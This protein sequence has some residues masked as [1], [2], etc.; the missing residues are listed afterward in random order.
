MEQ[1]LEDAGP[2]T[3]H[4]RMPGTV[5]IEGR[6][7][8]RRPSHPEENVEELQRELDIRYKLL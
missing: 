6:M 3:G 1:Q 7:R 5:D 8:P 4:R 2:Q